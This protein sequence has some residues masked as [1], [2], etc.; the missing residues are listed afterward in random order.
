M[1]AIAAGARSGETASPARS[2]GR[3]S[4]PAGA[5][6]ATPADGI[7]WLIDQIHT[8]QLDRHSWLLQ[9]GPTA[10]RLNQESERDG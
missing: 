1:T 3:Q 2:E 7:V 9:A 8:D 4:G 5:S 6:P 10:R